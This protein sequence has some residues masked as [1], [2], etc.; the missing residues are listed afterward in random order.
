MRQ[1]SPLFIFLL[2]LIN[3]SCFALKLS[4]PDNIPT[5]SGLSIGSRVT[6][7][8]SWIYG[9]QDGGAGKLGTVID[10]RVWRGDALRDDDVIIDEM[11]A[12]TVKHAAIIAARVRWD[13][14]GVVNAYRW[15]IAR[16]GGA[17]DI[18][19]VGWRPLSDIE[20]SVVSAQDELMSIEAARRNAGPTLARALRA[21]AKGLG[22]GHFTSILHW[23]IATVDTDVDTTSPCGDGAP[24]M[25]LNVKKS[26]SAIT[27]S[28]ESLPLSTSSDTPP[29]PPPPLPLHTT[30]SSKHIETPRLPWRGV[31][32]SSD[33]TSLIGI[34]FAQ[35]PLTNGSLN[36][37]LAALPLTLL[38]ISLARTGL[39]G[40][41][42][43]TSLCQ[44]T[45]LRF[46]DLNSN[47]FFGHLPECLNS[48]KKLEFVSL[49]SNDFEG[50]IPPIWAQFGH[51][52]TGLHL[53]GNVKLNGTIGKLL[54]KAL[55]NITSLTL[56]QNLRLELNYAVLKI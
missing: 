43:D 15:D 38:S 51:R 52:L 47:H 27:T 25:R 40:G 5:L 44:Q 49:A 32:C 24:A 39:T 8:P 16:A 54:A 19:P 2:L 10:F 28:M 37:F 42:F 33:G 17:R 35:I 34:D 48:L 26:T 6:R 4:V 30:P 20:S 3:L 41:G 29:P 1:H 18:T 14:S 53:H 11:A 50:H 23:P 55:A 13:E 12:T 45:S 46:I 22:G 36:G 56:P 31:I 7:G 9:E 21:A